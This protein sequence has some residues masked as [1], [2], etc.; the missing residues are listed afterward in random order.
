MFECVVL[1]A[2][3]TVVSVGG[4]VFEV[5]PTTLSKAFLE[6]FSAKGLDFLVFSFLNGFFMIAEF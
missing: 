6:S 3:V 4:A 2:A 5:P 1:L